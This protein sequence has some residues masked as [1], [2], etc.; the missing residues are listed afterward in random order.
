MDLYLTKA[1]ILYETAAHRQLTD[2][3]QWHQATWEAFP[4]KGDGAERDFLTRLERKP[5][6]LRLLILSQT[7]P[8]RPGWCPTDGW[9][10]RRLDQQFFQHERYH[11]SL[12]AN[13]TRKM[14]HDP[15][16]GKVFKDGK[17]RRVALRNRQ[18][19]EDWIARKATQS[20]FVLQGEQSRDDPED[21]RF[22]NLQIHRQPFE[23][24]LSKS[25]STG[26]PRNAITMNSV[27]FSGQL[28][29]TDQEL[30][31]HAFRKGIGSGKAFG[32]GM[33]AIAPVQSSP[34]TT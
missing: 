26:K 16:T 30:F 19:L 9:R 5:H 21:L 29:V 12:L 24:F 17:R 7:V 18:H 28:Q 6:H 23:Q 32:F 25:R 2:P 13:P 22:P 11:F 15:A 33:L 31:L 3:Y 14:D 34:S 10:T 4:D 1:E 20:G 27:E 8:V